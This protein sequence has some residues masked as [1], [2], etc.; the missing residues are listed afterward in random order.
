MAEP[1][2]GGVPG[3][4]RPLPVRSAG[5]WRKAWRYIGVYDDAFMLC[6]ATVSI[7]PG[8]QT[9]WA[10][11]D[12]ERR[13]MREG[14]RRLFPSVRPGV[15]LAGDHARVR[16]R[17]VEIDLRLDL[18]AVEAIESTNPVDD[19]G[20][21]GAWTWT[22]K[23]AG[24]PV[25]GSIRLGD[26]EHELRGARGVDD[27]SAGHHARRTSWHWSAG[28]GEGAD[29]QPL[30]WNLVTGINDPHT[31]S[32]RAV[33]VDGVPSEPAPVAFEG[34]DAVRF[35]DGS[36]LR[37]AA[38]GVRAHRESVPP[39]FSSDYEAPFGSF[40]GSLGGGVELARGL[41]VME[42]HDAVW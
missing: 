33:W 35:E 22:R 1:S 11:W 36:R 34:L 18:D 2:L 21:E 9:F 42:R 20:R 23:R 17:D 40:E 3:P 15:V 6:A 38:E 14:T 10:L 26:R 5:R 32:E 25:S 16:G 29:G 30:A 31:G 24:F 8:G 39:L 28:V 13:E 19:G 12:R 37:F 4:G 7:G 41:G 27:V